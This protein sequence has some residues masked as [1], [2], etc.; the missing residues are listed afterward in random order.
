LGLVGLGATVLRVAPVSRFR[1]GSTNHDGSYFSD[2][3]YS[4]YSLY[5]SLGS[6]FGSFSHSY[7]IYYHLLL[8]VLYFTVTTVT[9]KN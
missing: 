9:K 2:S 6:L 5:I 7:H 3:T 4:S 8:I 1:L